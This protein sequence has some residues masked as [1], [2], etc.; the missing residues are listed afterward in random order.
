[1]EPFRLEVLSYKDVYVGELIENGQWV[2]GCVDGQIAWP[3]KSQS[4]EF[5]AQKLHIIPV[6]KEMYPAVALRRSGGLTFEDAERIIARFLSA[7]SWMTEQGVAVHSWSGGNIPRSMGIER[8]HRMLR[9][10]FDF[11]NLPNTN[12]E[13]VELALALL[14][15]A[16]YINH[17]ELD[18]VSGPR[19]RGN[20]AVFRSG[21][22]AC[23]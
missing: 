10:A 4:V 14:R 16:R 13:A 21:R 6:T 8:P 11:A 17:P 1:V 3:V 22:A 15:E 19:G 9:N 20:F 2:V 7:L 12:D 23:S 18:P 5:K